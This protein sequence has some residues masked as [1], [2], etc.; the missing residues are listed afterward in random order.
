MGGGE[1]TAALLAVG[2]YWY[3]GNAALAGLTPHEG[4]GWISTTRGTDGLAGDETTREDATGTAISWLK[5]RAS[6]SFTGLTIKARYNA[7]CTD[8]YHAWN[9][10]SFDVLDDLNDTLW[11]AHVGFSFESR[12]A[13]F[14]PVTTTAEMTVLQ[15]AAGIGISDIRE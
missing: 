14:N 4:Q 13:E 8:S 2:E 11:G 7:G 6:S 5:V 15:A 12:T 10:S 9:G 1:S 3:D